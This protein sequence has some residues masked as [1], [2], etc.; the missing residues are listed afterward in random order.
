MVKKADNNEDLVIKILSERKIWKQ[1]SSGVA[2]LK[3]IFY[4]DHHNYKK[5]NYNMKKR[6]IN[7]F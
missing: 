2:N 1:I 7:H 6:V 4:K 3:W 5:M